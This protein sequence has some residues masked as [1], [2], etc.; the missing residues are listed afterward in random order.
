MTDQPQW[1]VEPPTMIFEGQEISGVYVK[2]AWDVW[3]KIKGLPRDHI[4]GWA[5]IAR[6]LAD[7]AKP[8]WGEPDK[9]ASYVLIAMDDGDVE[10]GYFDQLSNCW[11]RYDG[12]EIKRKVTATMPL[13]DAPE[14]G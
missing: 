11:R 13:P 4:D 14:V 2:E 6:A 1:A 9:A 7:A 12:S 5:M 8:K 3:Q 10:P